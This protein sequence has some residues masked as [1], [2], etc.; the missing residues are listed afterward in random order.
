MS[1]AVATSLWVQ[2]SFFSGSKDGARG[3]YACLAI[4]HLSLRVHVPENHI[5]TPSLYYNYYYLKPKY[6]LVGYMDPLGVLVDPQCKAFL[7][8]LDLEPRALNN[9]TLGGHCSYI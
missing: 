7:E 8:G 4:D 9:L 2:Q 3:M 1:H 5:L 6:L